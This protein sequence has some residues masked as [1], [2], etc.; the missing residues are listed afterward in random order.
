M[1]LNKPH[2]LKIGSV[3]NGVGVGITILGFFGFSATSI[4]NFLNN[5]W[6]TN[7][8][9]VVIALSIT[10]GALAIIFWGKKHSH[11]IV[12]FFLS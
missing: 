2:N 6:T 5:T 12:S 9:W 7:W 3:F 4:Y 10:F 11:T 8:W 1:R